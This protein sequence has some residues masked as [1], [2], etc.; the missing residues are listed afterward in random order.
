MTRTPLKDAPTVT[1]SGAIVG[2]PRLEPKPNAAERIAELAAAGSSMR[3]V[4][5]ALG[6]SKD[7][8]GRWLKEYPDLQEAFERGRERE[9]RE[10]HNVLFKAATEG[11]NIVAAMFLLKARHGYREGDQG[12]SGNRPTININLPGAMPLAQLKAIE[13][14]R[15]A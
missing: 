3:G 4:S 9:R 5:S 7:V 1:P 8:L 13:N 6:V 12:E 15:D 10:L 11:A 14:D 2:R